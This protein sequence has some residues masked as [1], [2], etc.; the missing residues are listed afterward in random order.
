MNVLWQAGVVA[1]RPGPPEEPPDLEAL[2]ASGVPRGRAAIGVR[3]G[4]LRFRRGLTRHGLGQ[5]AGMNGT[6][7]MRVEL[8]AASP[9]LETLAKLA[10]FY[11]LTTVEQL[12]GQLPS[13]ELVRENP[14]P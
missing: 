2:V 10:N 6:H 3:L 11:G 1:K 7:L 14:A 9:K 13:E 12:F 8:G 5:Q 4:E